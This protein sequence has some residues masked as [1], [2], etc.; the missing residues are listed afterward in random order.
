MKLDI[1][2]ISSSPLTETEPSMKKVKNT[3]EQNTS[4]KENLSPNYNNMINDRISKL[5]AALQSLV[6][7]AEFKRFKTETKD[8]I[9]GLESDN[10]NIRKELKE[11]IQMLTEI[12]DSKEEQIGAMQRDIDDLKIRLGD[13]SS[14]C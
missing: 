11:E 6:T 3:S 10:E 4:A 1:L 2:N 12:L 9:S 8:K 7:D 13:C 14:Q 5:Q